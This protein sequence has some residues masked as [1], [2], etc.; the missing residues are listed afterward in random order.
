VEGPYFTVAGRVVYPLGLTGFLLR[1]R[2]LEGRTDDAL[3]W[4]DLAASLAAAAG[5]G[6]VP[7]V[8]EFSEVDWTGPPGKGVEPGFLARDY[9]DYESVSHRM[10]DEAETRGV[11][12]QTV[13]LTYRHPSIAEAIA[14]CIRVDRLA[15]QHPNA[16]FQA[17]NEPSVNNIAIDEIVRLWTPTCRPADTGRLAPS[18]HPGWDYVG[19]HPPRDDEFCRKFKGGW[20]VQTGEGP[21]QPFQPPWRGGFYQDE[22]DRLENQPSADDWMS[23]FAGNRLFCAGGLIHGGQWA[24]GCHVE[25]IT[26]D[27]RATLDA[28]CRAVRMVPAQRYRNYYHPP[29]NGSLRRY[30]RDGD[31]GR[32]YEISVR[33][34]DFRIV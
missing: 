18:P 13:A 7:L 27:L 16:I 33:P 1:K 19:D 25:M 14:H 17:A 5:G 26:A 10:Y 15:A 22:P 20:E 28:I 23:F 30:Q 34:F 3:K 11:Y 24:Q 29:D 31:D 21:E 12:I 2:F 9:P 6:V 4:L 32:R 8:R